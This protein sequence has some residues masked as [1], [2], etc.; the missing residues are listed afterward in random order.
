MSLFT[1]RKSTSI[2]TKSTASASRKLRY[3]QL[4]NR[5][6]LAVDLFSTKATP[7]PGWAESNNACIDLS[8]LTKNSNSN[9]A[10]GTHTSSGISTSSSS[11]N[12]TQELWV[13]PA[14]ANNSVDRWTVTSN[15]ATN[16]AFGV[17][18]NMIGF[19]KAT[20]VAIARK[21]T[22]S[23]FDV[24]VSVAKNGENQAAFETDLSNQGPVSLSNDKLIEIDISSI[25]PAS[26]EAGQDSVAIKFEAEKK[27]DLRIIGLRFLYQ[28]VSGPTGPQGATGPVGPQGATGATGST[29]ATGNVG[30]QG[31]NGVQ[32][33]QGAIGPQGATGATGATGAVG[34]QGATGPIGPQGFIGQVGP[35]GPVGATGAVGPQG[36]TGTTGP[37]GI[38]GAV[39][40][41]G[42]VGATGAVGPQGATGATGSTGPQGP[43]GDV[44]PQG[45][46]GATGA[47]GPQGPIGLTGPQGP[48]GPAASVLHDSSLTGDGSSADPLKVDTITVYGPLQS[49]GTINSVSNPVDWTK[50]K[51][52]PSGFADG[53]DDIGLPLSGGTLSGSLAVTGT[54]SGNGSGLTS[55]DATAISSGTINAARLPVATSSSNGAMTALDKARLDATATDL[56]TTLNSAGPGLTVNGRAVS[57][58]ANA[59]GSSMLASD[60]TSLSKV[61]GGVL[62]V[63]GGKVG[64]GTASPVVSLDVAGSVKIGNDNG[65][66]NA[67]NAGAVRYNGIALQVSD[68]T[69]WQS[70]ATAGSPVILTSGTTAQRPSIPV[71]GQTFMNTTTGH[72]E[73]YDGSSW[74]SVAS[75]PQAIHTPDS[76]AGCPATQAA[77]TTLISQT[78]NLVSAGAVSV[79][80]R[81]AR[82][83][84]NSANRE[85][86]TLLVDNSSVALTATVA[87]AGLWVTGNVQWVGTLAA[88]THTI[89]IQGSNANAWGC[90]SQWGAIDTLVF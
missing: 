32:G 26:L 2:R 34:P 75:G 43:Q 73:W 50:L 35:Q 20:V 79:S 18:S 36:A 70:V 72:A 86:L 9:E 24:S 83:S 12:S 54:I 37:Q 55:I 74:R 56:A 8:N 23:K 4:E 89:A 78:I 42:A 15:G 85:D 1:F 29:G 31:N 21:T 38:T 13:A 6:L 71:V 48:A 5:R 41:Q 47:I 14:S 84:S 68:G 57:I 45:A 11:S 53:V 66:A 58:G 30:P 82:L 44:G 88:G 10:L 65:V 33:P 87:P 77:N 7:I 3:E 51:S 17:P 81:E 46:T 28:G 61:S 39:G 19:T 40:P 69:Q 67:S 49:A 16:F 60:A 25:I 76:R 63:S 27:S 62:S 80:A 64:I 59:V 52:V 22:T 90:G